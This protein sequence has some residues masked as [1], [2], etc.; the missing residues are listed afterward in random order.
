[1]GE[2][3]A[4]KRDG[5]APR[6]L[7]EALSR[8]GRVMR[9]TGVAQ[10]QRV[11]YVRWVERLH[12]FRV[13]VLRRSFQTCT[14]GDPVGLFERQRERF[15]SADWQLRQAS[16]AVVLFPRRVIGREGIDGRRI[17]ER[18]RQHADSC[19]RF[20]SERG[21]EPTNNLAEQ[22]IRFAAIH[23]RMPQGTRSEEGRRWCERIWTAIQTCGQQGRSVFAFLSAAVKAHFESRP[24]P[25]LV[26]DTC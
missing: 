9:E 11:Y 14:E 20:L 2:A 10:K 23:R 8:F 24:V 19:F 7:G 17:W 13:V 26:A 3:G 12:A 4:A 22:V 16:E 15:G 21:A 6:N 1:M 18:F 25:S 5:S